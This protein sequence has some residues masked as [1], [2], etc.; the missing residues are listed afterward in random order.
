MDDTPQIHKGQVMYFARIIPNQLYEL[1]DVHIR[2]VTDTYVVG[3]NKRDKHAYCFDIPV[4]INKT[5]FFHRSDALDAV[6]E[7]EAHR[8]KTYKE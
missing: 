5:L 3:V 1:L 7:A 4:E 2:T 8:T 6:K